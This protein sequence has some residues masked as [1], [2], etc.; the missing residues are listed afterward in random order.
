MAGQAQTT[1]YQALYRT[2]MK[3]AAAQGRLLMQRLVRRAVQSMPYVAARTGD[4]NQRKLLGES[5]RTLMKHEGALCEA[6]PQALLAEFAH[7]ISGDTRKAALSFDSLEL[8]GDEQMQESVDQLRLQ[9]MVLTEVEPDLAELN[10]LVCAVQGL[11]SVQVDRN[12]LRPEVYV[13]SLRTVILQSPVPNPMRN[14]WTQHLGEAL[15]PELARVYQELCMLMRAQGVVGAGFVAVPSPETDRAPLT[16]A[17]P[18]ASTLLNVKELR[19]LLSG[20]LEGPGQAPAPHASEPPPDFS[21]TMPAAFEALQ[22]MKQVDTVM[23]RMQQRGSLPEAPR[24]A[25]QALGQE[26]VTLM[27]EN[28][29]GDARLLP[30]VQQVVRELQPAL[31]R[32]VQGDP[33]FFSDRKHPARRLLEQMTQRSLAWESVEAPGFAAFMEPLRQAVEVLLSTQIEGAE[34]FDFALTSLEEAWGD[35]QQRDRRHREKAV[36][37]LLQAEQRNLLAEKIAKE[38]RARPDVSAA[39]REI[40]TFIAGP[41][42]QVMAQS[43]LGDETGNAD[44]GGFAALVA[45]L[46]WS[47]QPRV[48]AAHT[49]RLVKLVP[50]LVEKL[51][52]GL[53]TIDY[54][55]PATQRFLDY[56]AA[57]HQHA[58][59][60]AESPSRPVPLSTSMT[61]E[62]LEAMMGGDEDSGPGPWLGPTEAQQSGFMQTHQT[63]APKP[64]FQETQPGVVDTRP[65]A[66]QPAVTDAGVQPG[67]WVEMM[68]DGGWARYQVTWASPH[69]TLYM[70]ANA[71]GKTHSMTRRLLDK[72]LQGGLLR[73][74]SGQAVVDGALDAVAQA[75]LRNSVDSQP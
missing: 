64:L 29:A 1:P 31:L 57:A 15:A 16:G 28:I 22:E 13:R 30:P 73:M 36:R 68:I 49:A 39:P 23:K 62:E 37:A 53:A 75:A 35:Q 17:A 6:Y 41:W 47:A 71:A 50:L 2:C 55:A 20:E 38:M 9:Q 69:G 56:L 42:S 65:G 18:P 67:A 34:P 61:R 58:L 14:L 33:R 52:L 3:E 10:A 66:L 63:L 11:R 60:T 74:I 12:P 4:L 45:D 43:R 19:R 70:F 54:P 59:R 25:A 40:I 7:A 5:A 51:R 48:A 32:L 44:P 8:M 46:A 27:V 24:V 72:M 21:M 26:V